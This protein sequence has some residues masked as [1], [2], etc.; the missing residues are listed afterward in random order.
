MGTN[1]YHRTNICKDCNRF[2]KK[3]IGKS[4]AGWQFNFQGYEA[5]EDGNGEIK[6][7]DDWYEELT[8]LDG[9]IFD[10]YGKEIGFQEFTEFVQNKQTE[11]N[12]HYD[13]FKEKGYDMTNDWK[14]ALG[15]AFTSA[16]FS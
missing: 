14:D 5:D 1:Y 12:N 9:K 6:S 3:H 7:W 10:E 4:S 8:R 13:H 2:N 15:Y 11:R 16:E